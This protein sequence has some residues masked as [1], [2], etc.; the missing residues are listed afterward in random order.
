MS[1]M[2]QPCAWFIGLTNRVQAYCRLA[3]S[4]MQTMPSHNWTSGWRG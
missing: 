2:L 3:I 4:I 1:A